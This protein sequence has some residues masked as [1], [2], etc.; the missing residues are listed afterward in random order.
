MRRICVTVIVL[1]FGTSALAEDWPQWLG[2]RRDA[3]TSERIAPWTGELKVLWRVPVAGEGNSSPVVAAGRVF[4]HT[5]VGNE[6]REQ[7]TAFD[8]QSGE[9][10]WKTPYARAEVTT[11]YGNGPRATPTVVD[12]RVYTFGLSGLLTCFAAEKGARLWQVDTVKQFQPE[13]LFFGPSC[14]PLVEKNL[15]LL[16]VGAK[17]ASVVAFDRGNG[18]VVWKALNDGASY[19]SPI[20]FG[21]EDGRQVVFLTQEGLVSLKPADGTLFWRVPLKD[22]IFESSTTPVKAGDMLLGSSVTFGS[23]GLQLETKAGKPAA[24][25][26][27]KN[28]ALTCYFSTPVAV[29][30]DHVYMVIG[31]ATLKKPSASLRCVEMRTGKEL[32]KKAD[33]GSY[34]ASLLRTGDNKLLM[35]EE[36]GDLVL[37]NPDPSQYRE[38]ARSKIC[39]STWAHPAVANGR[40]Y[41]RDAKELICVQLPP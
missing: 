22:E 33:V 2:P 38:M 28:R 4:L 3:G 36:H 27:W 32:W 29:G 12:G 39:G 15:V 1:L 18:Q 23:L 37:L 34:H 14:S 41:I 25:Q 8:A 10:V 24:S 20:C 6:Q 17:G 16:N 31:Q 13:P 19:S 40:L 30:A 5:K 26:K 11:E 9:V 35:L 7:L 21:K